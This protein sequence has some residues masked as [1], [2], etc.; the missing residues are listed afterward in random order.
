MLL[1]FRNAILETTE[2]HL[3][4]TLYLQRYYTAL[5]QDDTS[6]SSLDDLLG[7]GTANGVSA[8]E[9]ASIREQMNNATLAADVASSCYWTL[10]GEDC[11]TVSIRC[12]SSQFRH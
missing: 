11:T 5:D 7:I 10:C 2:R 6:S 12:D 4:K 1:H 8:A 9:A 3:E